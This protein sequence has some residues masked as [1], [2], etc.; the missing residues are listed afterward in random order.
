MIMIMIMISIAKSRDGAS[1][2]SSWPLGASWSFLEPK[3]GPKLGPKTQRTSGPTKTYGFH[4]P[5]YVRPRK[6]KIVHGPMYL[7][8]HKALSLHAP[9]QLPA[10]ESRSFTLKSA[11]QTVQ[12]PKP[13]LPDCPKQFRRARQ[14]LRRVTLHPLTRRSTDSYLAQEA[15]CRRIASESTW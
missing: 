15:T 3:L 9:T 8:G 7:Q 12:C 1:G 13:A 2:S 14:A 5:T 4:A 6:T 10:H 11:C